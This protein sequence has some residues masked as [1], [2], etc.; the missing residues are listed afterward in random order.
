[1]GMTTIRTEMGPVPVPA[2]LNYGISEQERE[3]L[4][5]ILPT[6]SAKLE[7]LIRTPEEMQKAKTQDQMDGAEQRELMK[8][9]Q[10]ARIVDLRNASAQGIAYENR[11]RVVAA[12]SELGKPDDT[13]RPEVQVALLTMKIRNLWS[14][15]M[16]HKR[17]ISQRR[18]LRVLVHKRAK[19]LKYLKRTDRARYDVCLERLAIEPSAIE[20]EIVV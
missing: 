7:F 5:D 9:A 19:M 3:L 15:M 16:E 2:A 20:G 14:H 11:R 4:F 18:A 6:E 8:A 17:D 1:V 10:L 13:G 12:F